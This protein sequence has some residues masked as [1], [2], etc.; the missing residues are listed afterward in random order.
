MLGASGTK[1]SGAVVT[2]L[3]LVWGRVGGATLPGLADAFATASLP[4]SRPSGLLTWHL[5][6]RPSGRDHEVVGITDWHSAEQ[7]VAALG[8]ELGSD[9]TLGDLGSRAAL[10]GA[11]Y[12]EV[13]A[14]F[15]RPG[16]H[17]AVAL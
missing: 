4:T 11:D 12:Y 15:V 10:S 17:E 5:G 2:V 1:N 3:R 6:A 7:A 9:R 16:K 8:G 14:T 13:E